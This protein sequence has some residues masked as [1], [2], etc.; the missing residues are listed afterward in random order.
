VH[1]EDIRISSKLFPNGKLFESSTAWDDL[2]P[3]GH[4]TF[5]TPNGLT[6][7]GFDLVLV[8]RRND[9]AGVLVFFEMKYALLGTEKCELTLNFREHIEAKYDLTFLSDDE[10][11]ARKA[12]RSATQEHRPRQIARFIAEH[13]KA[14]E[15]HAGPFRKF[16]MCFSC[17]RNAF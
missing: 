10:G 15:S 8:G 14:E 2:A 4:V 16:S 6:N 1:D 3:Q 12:L 17:D 7:A 11:E 9:P 13:R 5:L